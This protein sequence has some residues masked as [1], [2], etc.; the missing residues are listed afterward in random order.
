MKSEL[1]EKFAHIQWLL[2]KQQIRGWAASGPL[3][4]TTRGQGRILAALKLRDGISTKD[5]SYLLG[6]RISSLNEMLSKLEKSG[7]VTREPSEHDRRVM[8]VYLTEKGRTE[9]QPEQSGY[10][11]IFSALSDEEQRT[12]GDYLD[13][14]I[15][16]LHARADEDK[17]RINERMDDLR[18][19]LGDI[20][21]FFTGHGRDYPG[22]WG[23]THGAGRG[24]RDHF[25]HGGNRGS[26]G[27]HHQHEYENN[28]DIEE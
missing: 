1:Y 2:H 6:I 26:H 4:D 7:Y 25:E 18:E 10:G 5:L 3:A 12:L 22:W 23:M 21:E 20:G 28:M 16:V 24:G 17:E 27:P 9:Q 19:R 8:L 11:D 15:S 13:R 14:I